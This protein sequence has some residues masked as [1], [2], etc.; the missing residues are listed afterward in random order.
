MWRSCRGNVFL[1]TIEIEEV[2]ISPKTDEETKRCVFICFFQGDQLQT[3]VKK[4]CD[5]YV[6]EF[7]KYHYV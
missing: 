1:K 6:L 4:I 3:R 2:I 7:S 5:G